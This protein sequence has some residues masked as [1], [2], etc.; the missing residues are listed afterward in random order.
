MNSFLRRGAVLLSF[1][2]ACV[3]A[4]AQSFSVTAPG[5][6]GTKLFDSTAGYTITGMASDAAGNLYYLE[7]DTTGFSGHTKLYKRSG[8]GYATITELYNFQDFVDGSFV[9]FTNGKVYF[10]ENSTGTIYSINPSGGIV[11][12]VGTVSSHYDVTVFNNQLFVSHSVGSANLISSF[13]LVGDG[14]GS[15]GEMLGTEQIILTANNDTFGVFAY[16]GDQLFYGASGYDTTK[17][18][19]R[20]FSSEVTA[21]GL[22]L[23]ESHKWGATTTMDVGGLAFG[24]GNDVWKTGNFSPELK[25]FSFFNEGVSTIG[26]ATGGD[27]LRQIDFSANSL[28]V[29][30]TAG[31][32]RSAIFTVTVPEPSSA[33][34]FLAGGL[35]LTRRR[36]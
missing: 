14:G 28:F 11:D 4:H 18:L 9:A 32:F 8:L 27:F 25:L 23:D 5:Y 20:F 34:A 36:R 1:L 35:V 33:L 6:T 16:A 7:T 29:N 26:S 10:G 22:T 13:A 24:S 17:G 3:C 31:T 21:G 15:G 12:T 19:Y 30:V 2:A